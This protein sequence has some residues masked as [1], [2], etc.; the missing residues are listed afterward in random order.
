MEKELT[1]RTSSAQPLVAPQPLCPLRTPCLQQHDVVFHGAGVVFRV[2]VVL[3]HPPDLLGFFCFVDV[4][5]PQDDCGVPGHGEGGGKGKSGWVSPPPTSFYTLRISHY[6]FYR[7]VQRAAQHSRDLLQNHSKEGTPRLGE[8]ERDKTPGSILTPGSVQLT[9][10]SQGP[11]GSPHSSPALLSSGR[12]CRGVSGAVPRG[13]P[14]SHPAEHLQET[15]AQHEP[16]AAE[17]PRAVP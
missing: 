16:G 1:A 6:S 15:P 13:H 7:Q 5:S 8:K 2:L 4:V 12:P 14:Q 11:P 3:E 9:S 10:P 17:S